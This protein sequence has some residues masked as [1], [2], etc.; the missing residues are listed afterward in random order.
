MTTK[1]SGEA[2]RKLQIPD[3]QACKW[4]LPGGGGKE[5]VREDQGGCEDVHKRHLSK[6]VHKGVREVW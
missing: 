5:R 3:Q 1:V 2:S 4:L 6:R